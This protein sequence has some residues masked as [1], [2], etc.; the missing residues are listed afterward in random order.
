M[1]HRSISKLLKTRVFSNA[2]LLARCAEK[3]AN[4]ARPLRK[5]VSSRLLKNP[6]RVVSIK[7]GKSTIHQNTRNSTKGRPGISCVIRVSSWIVSLLSFLQQSR[8]LGCCAS[9]NSCNSCESIRARTFSALALSGLLTLVPT[10]QPQVFAKKRVPPGGRVAVVVD[11]RLAALRAG[12]DLRAKLVSRLSRTRLVSIRGELRGT[13]GLKFYRVAINSR[14]LGWLQ[15]EAVV[16]SWRPGDDRRLLALIESSEEFDRIVRARTFLET[17]PRSPLAPKVLALYASEADNVADKLSQ[18]AQRRFNKNEIPT[19]GA[20]EFSY[21]LNYSSLDRYNREG[22]TFLFD[23]VAKKY[24]YDGAAWREIV[25]R[26]PK[27]PEAL[28]ARK[29]LGSLGPRESQ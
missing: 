1:S 4:V 2:T 17:F 23:R 20:P 12:P 10:V 22:V 25:R 15:S 28:E 29:H 5:T 19:D 3:I 26:Y 8:F 14:T 6:S 24:S 27:S 18:A 16:A 7:R 13:D 11:E 21:Y 9:F